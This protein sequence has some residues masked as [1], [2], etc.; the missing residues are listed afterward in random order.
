MKRVVKILL[1]ILLIVPFNVFAYSSD[2]KDVVAPIIGTKIDDNK[3]NLYLFKGDGC[4][5]CAQEEKW[6]KEIKTKY[7]DYLNVYE[8]E[9]WYNKENSNYL[10][11]VRNALGDTKSRGVPYTVIGN[12][13]FA[14]YSEAIGSRIESKIKEYVQ[15]DEDA[16]SNTNTDSADIPVLGK[17]DMKKVSIPLVAVVLGFIDGF[18]PCAMWIL[19]LLINMCIMAKDKKKMKVIG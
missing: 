18:N 5:H 14:G 9:V 13:Y 1:L 19:L 17:V 3:I 2:Y 8:F 10:S 4:P 15:F 12:S 6:L 7:K 11:E 16:S